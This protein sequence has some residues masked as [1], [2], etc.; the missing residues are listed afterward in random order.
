MKFKKR[1]SVSSFDMSKYTKQLEPMIERIVFSLGYKF[2]G[3][4]LINEE[5]TNYLRVTISHEKHS[6][7][8]D[9]CEL[10]SKEIGRELDKKDPIPF[11]YNLEVQSNSSDEALYI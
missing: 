10:V 8:L 2:I 4:S 7:T 9:D 11:P 6:I 5:Q 3:L 1:K